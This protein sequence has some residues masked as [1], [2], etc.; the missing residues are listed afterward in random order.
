MRAVVQRV[1]GAHVREGGASLGRIGPGL[2]VLLAVG[3]EDTEEDVS[4][5]SRKI[6]Q[7]RIFEDDTGKMN[8]SVQDIGG[9][10]LIVSEFT[11]FGDCRNGN[12]PSFI[13][14]APPEPAEKL[15]SRMLQA[16]REHGVPVETGRFQARMQIQLFN[17]GP[18]TI[19]LDSKKEF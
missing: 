14:A 7:L 2:M 3:R 15:F 8:L 6:V 12:R 5:L 17:E 1:S 18:V 11:L 19:I 16:I 4:Y 9:R 13:D 10:I